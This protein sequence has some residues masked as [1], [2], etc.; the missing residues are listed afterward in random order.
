MLNRVH[1]GHD[2]DTSLLA[3]ARGPQTVALWVLG[4]ETSGQAEAADSREPN[5]GR[6]PDICVPTE[7]S[8]LRG[9]C[10]V[11]AS[12]LLTV[13]VSGAM[14]G[15]RLPSI[16]DGADGEDDDPRDDA[17]EIIWELQL[18]FEPC[19]FDV[20]GHYTDDTFHL[21]V[22]G[23]GGQLAILSPEGTDEPTVALQEDAH[24]S[25]IT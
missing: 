20:F 22:G 5:E 21:V 23:K 25:D 15:W 16:N 12:T 19:V 7:R 14:V 18:G 9:L 2:P 1:H 17:P 13:H 6:K 4:N 3:V 11:G 24:K 10:F 8:A